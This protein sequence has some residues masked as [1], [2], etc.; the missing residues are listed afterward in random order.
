MSS[1]TSTAGITGSN[2]G[3]SNALVTGE[4]KSPGTG[5]VLPETAGAAFVRCPPAHVYGGRLPKSQAS[6]STIVMVSSGTQ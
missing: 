5:H 3:S 6:V 4:W 1:P 2:P